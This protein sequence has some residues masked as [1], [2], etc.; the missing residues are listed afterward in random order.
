[1]LPVSTETAIAAQVLGAAFAGA[2]PSTV[3]LVASTTAAAP[4]VIV[5]R[6][7]VMVALPRRC[8][9]V[10]ETTAG[11]ADRL[12]SAGQRTRT[13]PEVS[14]RPVPLRAPEPPAAAARRCRAAPRPPRPRWLPRSRRLRRP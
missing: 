9:L 7:V 13:G 1:M 3:A 12:G 10:T 11:A 6:M 4:R 8:P 5:E 2:A 14:S